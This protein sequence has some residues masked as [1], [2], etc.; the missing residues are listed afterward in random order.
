M[1]TVYDA[2]GSEVTVVELAD[3]LIP[4]CDSDL[5]KPLRKRIEKRYAAIHLETKVTEVKATDEAASR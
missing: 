2:L 4:G 3:Q 1:A 5:V